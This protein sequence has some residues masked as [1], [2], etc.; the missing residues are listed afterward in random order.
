MKLPFSPARVPGSVRRRKVCSM[1]RKRPEARISPVQ[2]TF[3]EELPDALVGKMGRDDRGTDGVGPDG[4]DAIGPPSASTEPGT[5]CQE[6]W[7][8]IDKLKK[9]AHK[10]ARRTTGIASVIALSR[11][12]SALIEVHEVVPNHVTDDHVSILDAARMRRGNQHHD[13]RH[14]RQFAAVPA[15]DADGSAT[16]PVGVFEGPEDSGGVAGR[17]DPDHNVAALG[18]VLQLVLKYGVGADVGRPSTG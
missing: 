3:S 15:G 5:S 14:G 13:V 4:S 17:A 2:S 10:K 12:V 18:G 1:A 6:A 8:T 9:D 16:D 11:T 7:H